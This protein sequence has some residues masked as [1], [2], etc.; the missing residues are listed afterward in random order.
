MLT[1]NDGGQE[2][3]RKTLLHQTQEDDKSFFKC[4]FE[5]PRSVKIKMNIKIN[6]SVNV[7]TT[8]TSTEVCWTS[9]SQ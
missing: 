8:I 5:M 3:E 6:I 7:K 4:S 9:G 1:K 2:P